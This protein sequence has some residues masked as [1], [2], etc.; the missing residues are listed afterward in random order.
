MLKI[1]I[2]YQNNS[3]I[4]SYQINRFY[5]KNLIKYLIFVVIILF[6]SFLT[7]V[8]SWV[9]LRLSDLD[10]K[11]HLQQEKIYKKRLDKI[12][13]RLKKSGAAPTIIEKINKRTI[14]EFESGSFGSPDR[15]YQ[16]F[17][18]EME[19]YIN[20]LLELETGF[21]ALEGHKLVQVFFGREKREV[22]Y[23][24]TKTQYD[25]EE[26]SGE[27]GEEIEERPSEE[28]VICGPK[29]LFSGL[30]ARRR[31]R[32]K[33]NREQKSESKKDKI[34]WRRQ[35]SKKIQLKLRK[36]SSRIPSSKSGKLSKMV[37][38]TLRTLR[39][40]KRSWM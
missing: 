4:V 33:S 26:D 28:E 24:L 29:R 16:L 5:E 20:D 1:L 3:V 13:G 36:K 25:D 8:F 31:K 6:V 35:K 12:L 9:C 21:G 7:I 30:M 10:Y 19:D 38:R 34:S 15:N 39:R 2:G 37:S 14:E 22:V 32:M 11:Q 17:F 18:D 40:S 23:E 27:E